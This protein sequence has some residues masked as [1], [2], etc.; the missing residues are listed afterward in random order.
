MLRP[1]KRSPGSL[2]GS[3]SCEITPDTD[4]T[5]RPNHLPKVQ[6]PADQVNPRAF[7]AVCTSNFF[8]RRHHV[9]S[10]A[11]LLSLAFC[12]V[13]FAYSREPTASSVG[14]GRQPHP[15]HYSRRS[16]E[17]ADHTAHESS[18]LA[19]GH[20][21][22]TGSSGR[23][24]ALITQ[25]QSSPN[26]AMQ[27]GGNAMIGHGQG[28]LQQG[29]VQGDKHRI[30]VVGGGLAGLSAAL[31]A[32]GNADDPSLDLGVHAC[33]PSCTVPWLGM[34]RVHIMHTCMYANKINQG[35]LAP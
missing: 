26:T 12:L 22:G 10:A 24:Q 3:G 11:L 30:C 1:Y 20:L 27:G 9:V 6:P 33:M 35:L 18:A 2:G 17:E 15:L 29:Q 31:T 32:A 5:T 7:L 28:N 23:K 19:V 25:G 34:T 13:V 21:R 16:E 8:R 4:D 14:S